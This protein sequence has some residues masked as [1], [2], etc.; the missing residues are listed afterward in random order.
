MQNEREA[1]GQINI[2]E[3]ESY[4]NSTIIECK[5]RLAFSS[6]AKAL[7]AKQSKAE[8]V[9][10]NQSKAKEILEQ[11]LEEMKSIKTS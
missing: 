2:K 11:K 6:Q 8:A 4:L 1:E 7:I 10:A 5:T 9:I 3:F